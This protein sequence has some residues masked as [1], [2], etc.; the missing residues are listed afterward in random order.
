MLST[1]SAY[2]AAQWSC[3]GRRIDGISHQRKLRPDR[4]RDRALIRHDDPT[5]PDKLFG[6]VIKAQPDPIVEK[7]MMS[8]SLD[9]NR[10]QR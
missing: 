10:Q 8:R 6:D 3:V 2:H 7:L 5:E 9:A 4:Q 1:V